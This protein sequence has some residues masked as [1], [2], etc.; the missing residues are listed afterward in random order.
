MVVFDVKFDFTFDFIS[1][2][3]VAAKTGPRVLES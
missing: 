3:F 2:H 1:L